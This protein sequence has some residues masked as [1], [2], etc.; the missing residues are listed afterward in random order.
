MEG[1]INKS[2][3]Q[4]IFDR[5]DAIEAFDEAASGA[6]S[7]EDNETGGV[8]FRFSDGSAISFSEQSI[9]VV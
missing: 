1:S 8:I 2:R 4:I 3:A 5:I 6:L 7:K 9:A